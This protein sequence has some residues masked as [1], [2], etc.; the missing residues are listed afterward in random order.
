MVPLFKSSCPREELPREELPREE[1]P[2]EEL[3]RECSWASQGDNALLE[4]GQVSS[5]SHFWP[6]AV[7]PY[8]EPRFPRLS[9]ELVTSVHCEA[10]G[11]CNG[12][13]GESPAHGAHLLCA[14]HRQP[15]SGTWS[16][17]IWMM[18]SG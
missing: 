14:Q 15:F 6:W 11:G 3:P 17:N 10:V 13:P 4:A 1:L 12:A 18:F 16:G 9:R 5:G 8:S 2:Q 7:A